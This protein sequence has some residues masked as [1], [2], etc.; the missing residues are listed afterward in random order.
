MADLKEK[1][2]NIYGKYGILGGRPKSFK[3]VKQFQTAVF[4]FLDACERR[5][6]IRY[7]KDGKELHVISRAPVTIEGFCAFSGITKTT[8]YEYAGKKGFA[9]VAA[10][11]KTICESYWVDQCAEGKPGNKADFV[12]KNSFAGD[13]KDNKDINLT[14]SVNT[15]N[16]VVI[17]GV[18]LN[19][20]IGEDVKDNRA[21][22]SESAEQTDTV[23]D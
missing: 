11:F 2:K 19:I 18:V 1:Y 16:D 22:N 8:F 14:G 10:K 13:W 5:E 20:G 9:D 21:G 6:V 4:D 23:S 12:L 15:M 7:D 3:N 17:D